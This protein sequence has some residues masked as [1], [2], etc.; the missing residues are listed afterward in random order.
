M[1]VGLLTQHDSIIIHSVCPGGPVE[2]DTPA[3]A[4][5]SIWEIRVPSIG[6]T[7][8]I[9]SEVQAVTQGARGFALQLQPGCHYGKHRRRTG[10]G[11]DD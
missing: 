5:G 9:D 8:S 1:L 6:E 10:A 4:Q 2:G 7:A 3:L 11:V